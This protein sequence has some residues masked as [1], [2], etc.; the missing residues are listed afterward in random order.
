M[1][2][3]AKILLEATFGNSRER[4][5]GK[6]VKVVALT[7]YVNHGGMLEAKNRGGDKFYGGAVLKLGEPKVL[8]ILNLPTVYLG[9]ISTL[10]LGMTDDAKLLAFFNGPGPEALLP[11]EFE[12][13][14]PE[15][16]QP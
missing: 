2:Q 1:E 3:K 15:S 10:L 4:L 7:E 8:D 14:P 6:R 9:I 5:E 13:W 11:N 16:T 12:Y